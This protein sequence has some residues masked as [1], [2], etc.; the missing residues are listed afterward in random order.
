M[1]SI[2]EEINKGTC[3]DKL[4]NSAIYG[5]RRGYEVGFITAIE[6]ALELIKYENEYYATECLEKILEEIKTRGFS[7][8]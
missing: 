2:K 3:A 7:N 1:G 6:K 4:S 8:E 5:F